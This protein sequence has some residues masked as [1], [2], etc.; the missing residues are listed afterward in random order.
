MDRLEILHHEL[1]VNN[2]TM[3]SDCDNGASHTRGFAVFSTRTIHMKGGWATRKSL[4]RALHEIGHIV[5]GDVGRSWEQEMAATRWAID[6][7][8]RHGVSIP[9]GTISEWNSYAERKKRHGDRIIAG[10]TEGK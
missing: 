5:T 4:F 1:S 3:C 8:R 7:M 6:A 2:V 10:R 9:K